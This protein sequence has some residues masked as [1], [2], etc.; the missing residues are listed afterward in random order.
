M[1]GGPECVSLCADP[2]GAVCV[3]AH[4]GLDAG[5]G[6]LFKAALPAVLVSFCKFCV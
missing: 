1:H 2:S 3:F 6:V 4:T 5:V